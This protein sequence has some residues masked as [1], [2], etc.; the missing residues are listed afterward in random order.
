MGCGLFAALLL[1]ACSSDKKNDYA[2]PGIDPDA[3]PAAQ[4]PMRSTM[5]K[6]HDRFDG[7][8][9]HIASGLAENP[10]WTEVQKLTGEYLEN[11]RIVIALDPPKGSKDSWANLTKQYLANAKELD[12]AANKKDAPKCIAVQRK[13]AQSCKSCHSVHRDGSREAKE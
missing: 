2:T 7:I 4:G 1:A 5:R 3:E 8:F 6:M 10:D 9:P 13:L 12:D 11:A